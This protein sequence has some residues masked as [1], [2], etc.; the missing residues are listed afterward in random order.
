MPAHKVKEP[1]KTYAYRVEPSVKKK[2]DK[3]AKKN[4]TTVSEILAQKLY[5]YNAE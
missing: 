5:D 1:K 2:A 3:K 4:K